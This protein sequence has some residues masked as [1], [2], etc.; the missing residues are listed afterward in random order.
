MKKVAYVGVDY[1]MNSLSIAVV[2][3]GEKR[4]HQMIRLANDDKVIAKYFKKLSGESEIRACY[5]AS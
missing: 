5:E 3:E 1:H 2:V 4:I